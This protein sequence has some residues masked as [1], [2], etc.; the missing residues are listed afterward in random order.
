M[1]RTLLLV[2]VIVAAGGARGVTEPGPAGDQR[3]SFLHQLSPAERDCLAAHPEIRLGIDPAW[4]PFEFVDDQGRYRGMAADYVGLLNS[5]LGTRMAP[6]RGLS[7]AEV[8]ARAD[9]GMI[10]V[11]PCVVKTAQREAFLNFTQS[12]LNF[13]MVIMTRD[14]ATFISGLDDLRT[15]QIGVVKGY[16]TVDLL[17]H[18]VRHLNSDRLPAEMIKFEITETASPSFTPVDLSVAQS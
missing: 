15:Q 4:E 7:W 5:M 14:D 18:I 17:G 3:Q 6:V 2:V 10:D 16:A 8:M 12:Y 11:L 13:P 9:A 1:S